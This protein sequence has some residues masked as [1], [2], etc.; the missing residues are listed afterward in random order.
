MHRARNWLRAVH[1]K[2]AVIVWL[3]LTATSINRPLQAHL[4]RVWAR[5]ACRAQEQTTLELA[6]HRRR[7]H[8]SD[9]LLSLLYG[10]ERLL[11]RG[12]RVDG[13]VDNAGKRQ[14]RNDVAQLLG[15]AHLDD[16]STRSLARERESLFDTGL[17]L[18]DRHLEG[19]PDE[20]ERDL[21]R[22]VR[23]RRLRQYEEL[24]GNASNVTRG[25]LDPSG[26]AYRATIFL[27]LLCPGGHSPLFVAPRLAH[28][29]RAQR[30]RGGG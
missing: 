26:P 9:T 30:G 23:G 22:Q 16:K 4:D 19:L 13:D 3:T 2:A 6:P 21:R 28:A 17:T 1:T 12:Q 20:L 24:H 29:R 27:V 14:V 10:L 25:H 18:L 5:L 7:R 11:E 8:L 15:G